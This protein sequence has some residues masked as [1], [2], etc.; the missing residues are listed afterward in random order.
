MSPS[1]QDL[2]IDGR[3]GVERVLG[4]S[5]G[6]VTLL[7]RQL[8]IQRRV[9]VR[10]LKN[11]DYLERLKSEVLTLAAIVHP[12]VLKVFDSDF[13]P[14]GRA[15]AVYDY[16]AGQRMDDASFPHPVPVHHVTELIRQVCAA[17]VAA[18]GTAVP[19]Y[20][21]AAWLTW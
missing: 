9:V 6:W 3:Y 8:G 15:F 1:A 4:R 13:Q 14:D 12:N 17:L 5:P 16:N 7:A 10:L 21:A 18:A 20:A 2:I 19:Q 11:P